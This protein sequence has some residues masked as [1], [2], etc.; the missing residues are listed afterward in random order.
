MM[1]AVL[2][3]D[4]SNQWRLT[5]ATVVITPSAGVCCCNSS[6]D[7]RL[8]CAAMAN[9]PYSSPTLPSVKSSR[10]SLAVLLPLACRLDTASGRFSSRPAARR[11]SNT[12][13][14][15]FSIVCS[16]WL[17]PGIPGV[18][19]SPVMASTGID[20]WTLYC[21]AR[22]HLLALIVLWPAQPAD[23]SGCPGR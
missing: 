20:P 16:L 1:S 4:G 3:R 19:A 21:T 15:L 12:A 10:F 18:S 5:G 23:R 7:R 2:A 22:S 9:S 11:D 14:G 17:F 6:V 8:R 13:A